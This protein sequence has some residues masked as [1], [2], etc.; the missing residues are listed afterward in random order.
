MLTSCVSKVFH[1][2]LANRLVEY[3]VENKFVDK[4]VQKA[5]IYGINGCI[6]H[7]Q[8]VQEIIADSWYRKRTV[9][10]TFF[11][12]ADAFGSVSHD[13]IS[14]SLKRFDVPQNVSARKL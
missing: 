6:E 14:Y 4:S 2:I 11:Y 10:I 5:F 3:F 8:V 9:H 13:I 7:N 12:I 1:Q